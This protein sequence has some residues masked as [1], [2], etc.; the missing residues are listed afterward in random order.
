LSHIRHVV[1]GQLGGEHIA[2]AIY[3]RGNR[4]ERVVA[5]GDRV[6]E[7]PLRGSPKLKEVVPPQPGKGYSNGG[8]AVDLD[9]D[10]AQELVVARGSGRWAHDPHLVWFKEMPGRQTWVEHSVARIGTETDDGPH[11]ILPFSFR[12]STG[13]AIKGVAV[14]VSRKK[15]VW[16]EIPED[17]TRPWKQH[18][19][20]AFPIPQ[21]SGMAIGDVAGNGRPDVACGMFWAECP[22]DPA[23]EPWVIRRFG[24][25]ENQGWGGM[26]KLALGDMD[27]DG[28]LEIVASEAEIPD[29][30]LGVFKRD[31]THPDKPWSCHLI[32]RG[33][34]CPHS[35]V[36]ADLNRDGRLDIIAGEMTAGGWNFPLNPD[37]RFLAYANEGH[38]KFRRSTLVSG[39][40]VHEMDLAPPG[41][42]GCILILAAD[43]IQPQKFPDMRTHVSTWRIEP[44]AGRR[45]RTRSA[46]ARS[47]G[48][49]AGQL[50][51]TDD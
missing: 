3:R 39:W 11:D 30:K 19:I 31:P 36:L 43:E 9:G 34:Y 37:P 15:L 38:L 18:E 44:A 25:W 48:T 22:A 20:G 50:H 12:N 35:L 17:P 8:C 33:L 29:A 28:K 21:Q 14:L 5:W 45:S 4:G 49:G 23:R 46:A 32:D 10:G 7:W 24:D 16:Y 51:T 2:H 47:F 42:N 6:L 40:G 1:L 27:G 13:R 41:D 26:A